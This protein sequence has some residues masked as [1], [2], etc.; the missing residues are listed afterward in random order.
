MPDIGFKSIQFNAQIVYI[1]LKQ[2]N[3]EFNLW[4]DGCDATQFNNKMY[5]NEVS[6][7]ETK[8]QETIRVQSDG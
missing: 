4:R 5:R 3:N 6:N 8:P 7:A 1:Q 2:I